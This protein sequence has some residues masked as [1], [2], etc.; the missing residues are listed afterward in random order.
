MKDRPPWSSNVRNLGQQPRKKL[1]NSEIRLRDTR[2][3]SSCK[4]NTESAIQLMWLN[5][6]LSELHDAVHR[7]ADNK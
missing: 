1:R 4:G 3:G 5:A 2:R 7:I 6:H